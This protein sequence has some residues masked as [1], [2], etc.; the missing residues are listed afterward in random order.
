MKVITLVLC[1]ISP[2]FLYAQNGAVNVGM[3]NT[4]LAQH[5][6]ISASTNKAGLTEIKNTTVAATYSLPYGLSQLTNSSIHFGKRI[7]SISSWS[8]MIAQQ[9][10]ITQ[11]A[12]SEIGFSY[13]RVLL[14]HLDLGLGLTYLTSSIPEQGRNSTISAS[15]GTSVQLTKF[16]TLHNLLT[17]NT[18]Q[19]N[20]TDISYKNNLSTG[21]SYRSKEALLIAEIQLTQQ[22]SP[23]LKFGVEYKLNSLFVTRLGY[24][25]TGQASVGLGIKKNKLQV[26]IALAEHL[27]LGTSSSTS[28]FYEF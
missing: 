11:L 8:T 10:K 14:E 22:T 5:D 24:S 26:D 27:A 19:D 21:I 13:G 12:Q 18:N 17:I 1:V 16:Y 7:D 23:L 20:S 15:I 28:L 6:L 25:S 2:I 4:T 9:G 3:G